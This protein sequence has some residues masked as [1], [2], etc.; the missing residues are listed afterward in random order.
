[1]KGAQPVVEPR[2]QDQALGTS[3]SFAYRGATQINAAEGLVDA[4]TL[5]PYGDGADPTFFDGADWKPTIAQI[6]GA[7]FFQVRIDFVANSDTGSGRG[8]S[9]ILG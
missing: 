4:L 1:M 3:V 6:D 2:P 7:R 8:P 5:D 9:A